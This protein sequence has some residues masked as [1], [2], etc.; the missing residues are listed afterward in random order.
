MKK[1]YA[2]LVGLN[3]Y[4]SINGLGGCVNDINRFE[5]Y[6]LSS[7]KVPQS[8]ILKL[9]DSQAPKAKIVDAFQ[10]HFAKA[11]KEDVCIF[12]FAGHKSSDSSTRRLSKSTPVL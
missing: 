10:T 8:Q 6:L 1:I 5:Q 2:L 11:T 9:L 7:L 3:K 4:Q 12:Y